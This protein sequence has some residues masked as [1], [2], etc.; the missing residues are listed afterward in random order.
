MGH[1]HT[2]PLLT[3]DCPQVGQLRGNSCIIG[4]QQPERPLRWLRLLGNRTIANNP[5]QKKENNGKK[6]GQQLHHD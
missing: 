4:T 2:V 1:R 5:N 6:T 3:D